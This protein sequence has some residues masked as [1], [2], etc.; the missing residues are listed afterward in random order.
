M[1]TSL[2][3]IDRRGSFISLRRV[4]SSSKRSKGTGPP[5]SGTFQCLRVSNSFN[6]RTRI[7]RAFADQQRPL[8]K[9]TSFCAWTVRSRSWSVDTTGDSLRVAGSKRE[10]QEIKTQ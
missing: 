9:T 10:A 2:R 6:D 1:Y 4:A 5:P 7:K 3:K 8:I